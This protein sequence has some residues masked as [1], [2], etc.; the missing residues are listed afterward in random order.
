VTMGAFWRLWVVLFCAGLSSCQQDV[1]SGGSFD[2]EDIGL[3]GGDPG[4]GGGGPPINV[5][6]VRINEVMVTNTA[7]LA[8]ET[9]AFPPWLELYNP[10]DLAVDLSGVSLSDQV[11]AAEKWVLPAGAAS[12]VPPHGYIVIFCDGRASEAPGLH[13]SFTLK[14][15]PLELVLNRGSDLFVAE[16]SSISPDKS[17]GRFPD[18][19]EKISVLSASTPGAANSAPM[20]QGD[21]I[22]GDVDRS[23][24]V[25]LADA[26]NI[27]RYLFQGTFTPH[28]EPVADANDDGMVNLTD[29]VGILAF[30][31][32]GDPPLHEL[33]AEEQ[34]AC[35]VNEPPI[36][37]PKPVYHTYP[38]YPIEFPIG[39]VD[40]EG[41]RLVYEAIDQPIGATLDEATGVVRWTPAA[42]QLGPFY[43]TFTVSDEATP[44]HRV[45]GRLAFQI[46]P[47]DGCTRPQCNPARGC[48]P[49]LAPLTESCCGAPAARV[50][51]PEVGCPAGGVLHVGRN[52]L[53]SATIGRVGNCDALQLVALGQGGYTM[54]L[55][56]EAR[57]LVPS[58]VLVDVRLEIA[59][60]IL[61]D[62]SIRLD[63]V[64]RA[65]GYVV[66]RN[67]RL[68]AEGF[69]GNNRDGLLTVAATDTAGVRLERKLRLILTRDPVPELP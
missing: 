42:E 30:L 24:E 36:L 59:E 9:G 37:T 44:P 17:L 66:L 8:D 10:T 28:C 6:Q 55:N 54:R 31:F 32:L 19:G 61:F 7:T 22:R 2:D 13:A 29:A 46:H 39:A 26:I 33:S 12:V 50:S 16:G 21:G 23:G 58:Q 27:L 14:P 56:F 18:G 68:T 67:L 51:D 43:L 49:N 4:P 45:G 52:P 11:S 53:G 64:P 34:A 69:T 63:F 47:L 15:G 60:G 48:E 1:V 41:G 65:D 62:E 40:P 38:G 57:C 25:D 35:I 20:P 5:S 3:P